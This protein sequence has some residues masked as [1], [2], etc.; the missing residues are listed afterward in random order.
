MSLKL[1]SIEKNGIE[2]SY[3]EVSLMNKKKWLLNCFYN[4]N[5]GLIGS[6]MIAVSKSTELCNSKYEHLFLGAFNIGIEDTLVKKFCNDFN[7]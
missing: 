7:L 6:H 2:G 4:P 3:I 1:L 5:K